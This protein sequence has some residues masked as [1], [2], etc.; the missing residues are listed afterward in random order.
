VDPLA[1]KMRNWSPYNYAFNNPVRFIDV[2]GMFP[3]PVTVRAFAPSGAFRGSGFGDDGRGYSASRNVTSRITQTTTIDPSARTVRGG[4]ATSSDTHWNGVYVGNASSSNDGSIGKTSF[5][6]NSFG[7]NVAAVDASFS[8]SN[9]AFGG[10]APNIEVKS[11]ILLSENTKDGYVIA[12]IDLSS[13]EFPAT[14][15]IIGDNKG[16][17]VF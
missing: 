1:E 5:F 8:G 14:E 11:S 10:V 3:Y 6:K 12:S 9:P 16:Q 7:S 15:A 2:D 17:S 4:A 13:K